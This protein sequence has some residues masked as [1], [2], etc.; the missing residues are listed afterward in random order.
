MQDLS[1]LPTLVSRPSAR[2]GARRSD[3]APQEAHRR[4]I[5]LEHFLHK[6]SRREQRRELDPPFTGFTHAQDPALARRL[7]EIHDSRARALHRGY[8]GAIDWVCLYLPIMAS[9]DTGKDVD[10]QAKYRTS[11]VANDLASLVRYGQRLS[12][13]C[14]LVA[15]EDGEWRA[16]RVES[17]VTELLWL[18]DSVRAHL[19]ATESSDTVAVTLTKRLRRDREAV[20]KLQALPEAHQS[21][22]VA[23][24]WATLRK[25][26]KLLAVDSWQRDFTRFLA[27]TASRPAAEYNLKAFAD[28]TPPADE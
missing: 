22:V 2:V 27:P 11:A 25:A 14:E 1:R 19:L 9:C 18:P 24:Y 12:E 13:V 6:V 8:P 5:A 16:V 10:N 17:A 20:T 28:Q 23:A 26:T 7:E 3:A 21:P 4:V 15:P